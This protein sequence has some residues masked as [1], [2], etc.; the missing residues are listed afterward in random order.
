MSG[1]GLTTSQTIGPFFSHALLRDDLNVLVGPETAGERLRI[2]GRILDGDRVP[3]PDA[4]VEIWQADSH[5]RYNHPLDRRAVP[6][7]PSFT[8]FG[9]SGTDEAGRFW[10]ETVK[11]GPV[12][13]DAN[14]VQAPHLNVAVFARG[15]L[16]HATTR[17]YFEDEPANADDP[18]LA[19]VPTH[20]RSTLLAK[21]ELVDGTVTYRL[22]IV[23]Q[24]EGET[25]F[26]NL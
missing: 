7:D 8:G 20:R 25:V 1:P 13:F 22:D 3:V 11:P 2:E 10:F 9:R 6:L 26:F 4:M 23:L 14:S 15:M 24:G 19:R 5:G 18:F 16:N 17:F 21:R 12:P